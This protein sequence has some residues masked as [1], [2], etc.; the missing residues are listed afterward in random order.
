MADD[1]TEFTTDKDE[2]A[3][4]VKRLKAKLRDALA[5]V[6]T[7]DAALRKSA[8]SQ[9]GLDPEKGVGRLLFEKYE[10]SDYTA[11]EVREFAKSNDIELVPPSDGGEQQSTDG[12]PQPM[13]VD[14][15]SPAQQQHIA[16]QQTA[17]QLMDHS[18]PA[19][20]PSDTD[21]QL[22]Q[23][24]QDGDYR[25]SIALKNATKLLPKMET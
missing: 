11:D 8:F 12:R 14:Q 6:D 1:L 5:E 24:Y 7:K 22:A 21:A 25:S 16:A 2:D 10:G 18:L 20:A 3:P 23:A 4:F 15:R 17:T 13:P 19:P 9:A